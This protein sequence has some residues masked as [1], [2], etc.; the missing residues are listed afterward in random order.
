M[1]VNF[2]LSK[3]MCTIVFIIAYSIS[4]DNMR[5]NEYKILLIM[6]DKSRYLYYFTYIIFVYV[7]M[8]IYHD[9]QKRSLI[10]I[11][12]GF[13]L[14]IFYVIDRS[15][16]DQKYFFSTSEKLFSLNISREGFPKTSNFMIAIP[17]N[18]KKSWIQSV[19]NILL[20]HRQNSTPNGE[21]AMQHSWSSPP[22]HFSS[23]CYIS[24]DE[25]TRYQRGIA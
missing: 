16:I 18:I 17:Q 10:L 22:L 21:D 2:S 23:F 24:R 25:T 6:Y 13:C 15:Q 11:Y 4:K 19:Q 20:C 9:L 14:I 5:Q 1:Q 8:Q 7:L 3:Q 12:L